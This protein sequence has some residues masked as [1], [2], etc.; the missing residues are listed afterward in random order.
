MDGFYNQNADQLGSL[1][2]PSLLRAL[3]T[4]W[5]SGKVSTPCI[6]VTLVRV[7][8]QCSNAALS[9]VCFCKNN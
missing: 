5:S 4:P 9:D 6:R 8:S 3:G 2:G 7:S 1:A